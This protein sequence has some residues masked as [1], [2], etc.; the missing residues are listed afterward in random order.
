MRKLSE[1]LSFVVDIKDNYTL[2]RNLVIVVSIKRSREFSRG[3]RHLIFY[4]RLTTSFLVINVYKPL[5]S[6]T[7]DSYGTVTGLP[8][9]ERFCGHL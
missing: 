1:S 4:V 8:V 6:G 9:Q 2:I 5:T 7:E 3:I